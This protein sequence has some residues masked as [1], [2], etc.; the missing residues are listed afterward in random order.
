MHNTAL[1]SA[2]S[3]F[4]RLFHVSEESGI[5][6]FHPR[7]PTRKDMTDSPP[8]IWAIAE[9]RLSNFLTPRDCP[10]VCFHRNGKADSDDLSLFS[11]P[12]VLSVLAIERIWLEK[13]KSTTLYLYQFDPDGFV[14]QDACAGYYVSEKTQTPISVTEIKDVF[15]L[16]SAYKTE[17]LILDNLWP[18]A[19]K[20]MKTNL[21]WSLCRMKNAQKRV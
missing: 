14:L 4:L 2:S 5:S 18:L 8:L 9:N 20:V 7:T 12:D 1:H 15:P 3:P 11:S 21:D 6:V 19:D 17:V 16:L 10:R 13:M